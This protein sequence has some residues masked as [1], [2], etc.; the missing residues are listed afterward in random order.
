MK[1]IVGLGNPE[2]RYSGTRHNVGWQILDQLAAEQGAVF[3]AR[4]KFK[5]LAAEYSNAGEKVLLLK[6]TTYYNLS[7]ESVRA[8][9]DF[10]KIAPDDVLVVHDDFAITF[11]T[12]RVR[13]QGGDA[14]NNGIK[15]VNSHLGARYWR[16]RVGILSK[17]RAQIHD[18]A[19]VLGAFSAEEQAVLQNKVYP[20]ATKIIDNFLAGTLENTSVTP[21]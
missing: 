1:L 21:G 18:I 19:F 11:G 13:S 2:P 9:V 5:A 15:S 17:L 4:S 10:Y 7:G 3:T 16:L 14:G 20:A 8:V 6:P 12:L